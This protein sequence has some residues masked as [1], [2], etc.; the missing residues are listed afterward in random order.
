MSA[1]QLHPA[2]T[3]FLAPRARHQPRNA[4]ASP[5]ACAAPTSTPVLPRSRATNF[6][7]VES[8]AQRTAV[9]IRSCAARVDAP[10]ANPGTR[11]GLSATVLRATHDGDGGGVAPTSSESRGFDIRRVEQYTE[12]VPAEVVVLNALVDGEED[13]VVVFRGFSSSLVLPTPSDPSDPVLP[14]S[15]VISSVDRVRGP[16]NPARMEYIQQGMRWEEFEQLL[17]DMHL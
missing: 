15:A 13:E 12:R 9:P 16:F 14:A 1:A 6:L 10:S 11:W 8:R 3:A 2:P 5:L 17:E 7:P 4:P